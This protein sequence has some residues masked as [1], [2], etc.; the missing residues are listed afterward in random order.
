MK[1]GIITVTVTEAFFRWVERRQAL[2]SH[3]QIFRWIILPFLDLYPVNLVH[4]CIHNLSDNVTK[5]SPFMASWQRVIASFVSNCNVLFINYEAGKV[6]RFK[7]ASKLAHVIIRAFG[8]QL[9]MSSACSDS[10]N[11]REFLLTTVN[12]EVYGQFKEI[13][14]SV[15]IFLI[16]IENLWIKKYLDV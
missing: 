16:K 1:Y 10:N 3:M 6:K 7:F 4:V 8:S 9:L 11:H 15:F 5:S 2:S 12:L 14:L 13:S